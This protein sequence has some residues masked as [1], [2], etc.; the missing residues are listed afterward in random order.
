MASPTSL[1]RLCVWS[2]TL[3]GIQVGDLRSCGST[4]AHNHF[5]SW[6]QMSHT[7]VTNVSSELS[8][9]VL[10]LVCCVLISSS[11]VNALRQNVHWARSDNDSSC[12]SV[13]WPA[14]PERKLKTK[15][16][17]LVFAK[18]APRRVHMQNFQMVLT[19][20]CKKLRAHSQLSFR[21]KHQV[22]GKRP[23]LLWV[24]CLFLKWLFQAL[25]TLCTPKWRKCQLQ[26]CFRSCPCKHKDW[27]FQFVSSHKIMSGNIRKIKIQ[28]KKASH[29]ARRK[30]VLEA[31][32]EMFGSSYT[33]EEQTKQERLKKPFN[34][35]QEISLREKH[36][37]PLN[38]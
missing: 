21:S 15:F 8:L 22:L 28:Q 31:P 5:F 37:Y 11:N 38:V 4:E 24:F 26:N 2:W 19:D 3:S 16:A 13:R 33:E 1:R 34:L 12:Y 6:L 20:V 17:I 18:A 35:L 9:F 30:A 14:L 32:L 7:C 25:D 27:W 23:N 10:V 36:I 29:C